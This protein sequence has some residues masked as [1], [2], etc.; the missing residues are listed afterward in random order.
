M[1]IRINRRLIVHRRAF[2]FRF[3]LDHLNFFEFFFCRYGGL[4]TGEQK[5]YVDLEL[6]PG[7]NSGQPLYQ[8][9]FEKKKLKF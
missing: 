4:N 9:S 5:P 2:C 3:V 8:G 7:Q 1:L 6:H